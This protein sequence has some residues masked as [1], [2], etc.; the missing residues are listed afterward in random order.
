MN[1][2]HRLRVELHTY[3][4]LKERLL[5]EV[6]DIDAETLADTLEGLTDLREMIAAVVRS[7]LE[8]EALASALATRLADMRE[9]LARLEKRADRKRE[10]ALT[11]MTDADIGRLTEPD[12]TASLRQGAP[13]LEVTS[14]D[15]LP[16][17]YWKPQPPKVDRQKLL[18]DL[19]GG[20]DVAGASLVPGSLQLTVRSK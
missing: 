19:K 7:A 16:D 15:I 10:L 20:A 13:Q 3:D 17:I 9:R 12:F 4:L 11:T 18:N 1:D 5:A 8:D 14:E 6:P 2:S